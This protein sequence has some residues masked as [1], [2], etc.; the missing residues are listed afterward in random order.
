MKAPFS[1]KKLCTPAMLYFYISIF[2]L[3]IVFLQNLGS[4]KMFKMGCYSCP[5]SNN[6]YVFIFK[7][8]YILFWTWIL[9]LL[10]TNGYT[11]VSWILILLPIIT[12]FIVINMF[13]LQ[14]KM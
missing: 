1:V 8:L 3:I 7:L 11:F 2:F 4:N 14:N 10:C 5:V 12:L 6:I 9:N 13:M